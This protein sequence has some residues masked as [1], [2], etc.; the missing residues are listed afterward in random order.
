MFPL[1]TVPVD[2]VP[3]ALEALL[4]PLC[5]GIVVGLVLGAAVVFVMTKVENLLNRWTNSKAADTRPAEVART[6]TGPTKTPRPA[7]GARTLPARP[8]RPAAPR[9]ALVARPS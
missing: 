7:L 1:D 4:M 2:V 5:E 8:R 3:S 6:Q 9:T